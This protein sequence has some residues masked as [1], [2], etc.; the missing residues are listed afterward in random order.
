[1]EDLLDS[2]TLS[3]SPR[4]H[5]FSL[6][7][8]K[9]GPHPLA[10]QMLSTKQRLLT[11]QQRVQAA[12]NRLRKLQLQ[13]AKLKRESEQDERQRTSLE[14]VKARREK[15]CQLKLKLRAERE[16]AEVELRLQNLREKRTRTELINAARSRLLREKRDLA[17]QGKLDKDRLDDLL[18]QQRQEDRLRNNERKS[19]IEY[20]KRQS[21]HRRLQSA[22]GLRDTARSLYQRKLEE[23][24]R[25][26]EAREIQAQLLESEAN[27]VL[28]RLRLFKL[29]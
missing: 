2:S 20:D 15:Q 26:A 22:D 9:A 5:H 21:Q 7:C 11:E 13:E 12:E 4:K 10:S 29:D 16:A 25:E 1:M 24:M 6:S 27:A 23:E 17:E 14:Q 28:Q 3:S 19:Q 8:P 18:M